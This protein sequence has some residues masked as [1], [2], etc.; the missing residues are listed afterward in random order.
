MPIRVVG[1][2]RQRYGLWRGRLYRIPGPGEQEPLHRGEH[3]HPEC[4]RR[5]RAARS[6]STKIR[7]RRSAVPE[8]YY[9]ETVRVERERKYDRF[10][11]TSDPWYDDWLLAWGGAASRDYAI[12]IDNYVSNAA[13]GT[14]HVGMWGVTDFPAAPDHHVEVKFNGVKVADDY[15]DGAQVVPIDGR[16]AGRVAPGRRQHRDPAA[17]LHG[18]GCRLWNGIWLR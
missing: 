10:S 18:S 16:T 12:S 15:F 14:L 17:A 2:D 8:P 13:P 7:C 9:F 1:K 11:P 6:A 3:L 4:R 5:E